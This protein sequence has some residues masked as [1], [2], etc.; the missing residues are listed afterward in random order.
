MG[1]IFVFRNVTRVIQY[2]LTESLGKLVADACHLRYSG[3]DSETKILAQM[4][5]ALIC[6]SFGKTIQNPKNYSITKY[7]KSKPLLSPQRGE[8][9]RARTSS[10]SQTQTQWPRFLC[11]VCVFEACECQ[12][13]AEVPVQ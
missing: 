2:E 7:V 3:K 10:P 9:G 12:C 1:R 6:S 11:I 8:G 13:H 4:Q 5:K